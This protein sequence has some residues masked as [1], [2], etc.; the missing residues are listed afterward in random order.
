[1]HNLFGN[2]FY[3]L[4]QPAWH[5]LGVVSQEET[6]AVDAFNLIHP[7]TVTLQ[8]LYTEVDGKKLELSQRSI[9]RHPVPDDPEYKMLGVVG[10]EY[11]LVDPLTLC[12]I[13]DDNVRAP[14]ETLGALGSGETL[15]LTTRLASVN[16]LGDDV[17]NYL[18]IVS[19]YSGNASIQ[20]RLTPVRVVC[21]NTLMIAKRDSTESYRIVHDTLAVPRL[22]RWMSGIVERFQE[23]SD[24]TSMALRLMAE[25]KIEKMDVE[26]L[27]GLIYEDPKPFSRS[28]LDED[29]SRRSLWFEENRELVV[30][31]RQ[32]VKEVFEGRGVGQD[33][34]AAAGTVWGLFNA[35]AEYEMYRPTTKGKAASADMLLGGRA[36]VSEV[37]YGVC[38]NYVTR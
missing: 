34:V 1:M 3:T 9:I 15:F 14:V 6:N 19:P 13:Y 11:K 20:V 28:V 18:L 38:L 22:A 2:R 7:F 12:E 32:A 4:R 36:N 37:A 16:I 30:R 25:T 17:D 10:S 21:Q 27:L 31:R 5:S 8:P 35:V 29:N 33:T 24:E 23:K 26:P